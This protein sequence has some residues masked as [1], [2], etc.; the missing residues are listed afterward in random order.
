MAKFVVVFILEYIPINQYI[1]ID[2][3]TIQLILGL[4]VFP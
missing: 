3:K 4:S 2:D 1:Q